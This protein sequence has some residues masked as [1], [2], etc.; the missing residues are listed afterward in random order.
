MSDGF[1]QAG[2]VAHGSEAGNLQDSLTGGPSGGS[3][4]AADSG[5]SG[6]IGADKSGADV[7]SEQVS[8]ALGGGGDDGSGGGDAGEDGGGNDE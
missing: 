3:L 4:P 2:D 5:G 7:V 8:T 6:A 1:T